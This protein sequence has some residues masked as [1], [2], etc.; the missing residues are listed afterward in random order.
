MNA[1][2]CCPCRQFSTVVCSVAC[3]A[4]CSVAWGCRVT[5][6]HCHELRNGFCLFP[7]PGPATMSGMRA[8][9]RR[10]CIAMESHARGSIIL[11][12]MVSDLTSSCIWPKHLSDSAH[13][14]LQ[15]LTLAHRISAP[16]YTEMIILIKIVPNDY[17]RESPIDHRVEHVIKS[18]RVMLGSG[19]ETSL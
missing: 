4:A 13:C 1:P 8:L 14:F 5:P 18:W 9:I 6:G 16:K 2:T 19:V 15:F 3:S 11:K 7:P 12:S 10:A 17:P